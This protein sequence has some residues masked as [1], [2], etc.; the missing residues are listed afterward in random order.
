MLSVRHVVSLVFLTHFVLFHVA[1]NS[2]PPFTPNVVDPDR[3][4]SESDVTEINR[5]LQSLRDKADIWG[6]VFLVERLHEDTIESLA[7]RAFKTWKLGAAKKSNGLLLLLAMK[8]RRSRFEVGYGL[9]GDLPDAV[10]RRA[11][12]DVLRP[13]MRAGNVRAAITE[14]FIYLAAIKTKDPQFQ[15][16]PL[17]EP[18]GGDRSLD[19]LDKRA[20]LQGL[21]LFYFCL[22]LA[23]PLIRTVAVARARRLAT[24]YGKYK[25]DADKQVNYGSW[26]LKHLLLGQST[27]P[28]FLRLFFTVNPGVF[29]FLFCGLNQYVLPGFTAVCLLILYFVFKANAGKYWSA[30]AYERSIEKARKRNQRLVDK[31]YMREVSPGQ[32]DYTPSY[33]S[34]SEYRSSRSSSSGSSSSSSSSSGGGSSGGGGSSSSW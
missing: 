28:I 34:S 24:I 18:D 32:F 6:A 12:D 5:T 4:L 7:E 3:Q 27:W 25:I 8:D 22:W 15:N 10:T 26:S 9:E 16:S 11:L 20:G 1:A 29:I 13:H 30:D 33:Y 23:G 17:P 31:G 2:I 14:A 19:D 21:L